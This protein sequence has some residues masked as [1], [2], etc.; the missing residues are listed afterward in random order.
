MQ[1]RGSEGVRG[2]EREGGRGFE[3]ERSKRREVRRVSKGERD[4]ERG[5]SGWHGESSAVR[6]RVRCKMYE[7]KFQYPPQIL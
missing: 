2:V 6:C 5:G 7:S 3:R 4:R 1:E